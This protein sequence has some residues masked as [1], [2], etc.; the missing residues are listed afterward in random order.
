M[1]YSLEEQG[2]AK[3]VQKNQQ[4]LSD[5]QGIYE[6][7][8]QRTYGEQGSL[9]NHFIEKEAVKSHKII[10][11][12]FKTYWIVEFGDKYY[13]IDQHAAHERVL[14]EQMLGEME[15]GNIHS[16]GLLSPALVHVSALELERYIEHQ[17]LFNTL[18]FDMEVFGDDALLIRG[19]PYI[20]GGAMDTSEFTIILDELSEQ[21][22]ESQ[23]RVILVKLASMSCKAAVKA[24]D[25][26]TVLECHRL[27]DDLL[28]LKNPFHCPHGRPTI[29]AM[30]KYELEK[31][32]KRI[33]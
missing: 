8:H 9:E 15:T 30:T 29:I 28:G 1:D 2:T 20:F 22:V 18:G 13:I 17:S 32:F 21:Y 23:V 19:V 3:N 7:E 31:K 10:G 24:H 26:L 16:Q 5:E 4:K 6:Q 11:Q 33:V 27:I 14:Y 12:M 25:E